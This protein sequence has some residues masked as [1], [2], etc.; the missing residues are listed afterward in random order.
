[1]KPLDFVATM[2]KYITYQTTLRGNHW[3]WRLPPPYS[4]YTSGATPRTHQTA[5]GIQRGDARQVAPTRGRSNSCP[6][7]HCGSSPVKQVHVSM[8]SLKMSPNCLIEFLG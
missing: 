4:G 5:P 1:M 2:S 8:C 6:R 3:R 7:L